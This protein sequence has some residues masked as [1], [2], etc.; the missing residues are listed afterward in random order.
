MGSG[1]NVNV[2]LHLRHACDATPG[3]GWGG[4]G[5][6]TFT[7]ACVMHVILRQAWGGVAVGFY[8]SLALNPKIDL[9]ILAWQWHWENSASLGAN[10]C[11]KT[12]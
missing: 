8:R 9:C 6:L 1:W 3:M 7:C 5:M 11:K 4:G 2:H 12:A 10:L